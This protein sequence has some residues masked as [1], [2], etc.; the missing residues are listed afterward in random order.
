MF[1]KVNP[2]HPD[3]LADRIAG[4]L[5]DYAMTVDENA[6]CGIEVLLGHGH[7]YIVGES[8]VVFPTPKVDEIVTRIVGRRLD[9]EITIAKQDKHLAKNQ[10]GRVRCGDN[11]IFK[12]VP[13][14]DEEKE[15][16]EIARTIYDDYEYD[17]KYILDNK[18][19]R[20]I[21]C[22]SHADEDL[23]SRFTARAIV[24]PLGD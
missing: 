9:L 24:N 15:L 11:G 12:G 13:L 20:L 17:G 7:C 23:Y 19:K 10:E 18:K 16:A 4:A 14:T 2:K 3:K 5:V 1:E 6:K 8:S 21:V 22:Q